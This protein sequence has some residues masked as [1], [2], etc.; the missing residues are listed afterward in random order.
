MHTP[1]SCEHFLPRNKPIL[2][3]Y[4]LVKLDMAELRFSLSLSSVEWKC[5]SMKNQDTDTEMLLHKARRNTKKSS[6]MIFELFT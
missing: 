5:D 4:L 6:I 3:L 1:S 2:K